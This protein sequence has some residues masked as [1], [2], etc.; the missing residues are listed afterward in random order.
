M[1]K[2]HCSKIFE[3][4]AKETKLKT[5]VKAQL[6]TIRLIQNLNKPIQLIDRK[7]IQKLISQHQL[8]PPPPSVKTAMIKTIIEIRVKKLTN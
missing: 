8:P 5:T 2:L 4:G 7:N 6:S 1:F 3:K